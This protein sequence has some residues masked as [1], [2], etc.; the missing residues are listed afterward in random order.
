MVERPQFAIARVENGCELACSEDRV[1]TQFR[2]AGMRRLAF[3]ADERTQ[4]P[5]VSREDGVV[6][7]LADHDQV[8]PRFLLRERPRAAAVSLLVSDEH[9]YQRATP[10]LPPRR[11]ET[12]RLGHGRNR[13]LGVTSAP[14]EKLAL[15]L[16]QTKRVAR[17]AAARGNR[18]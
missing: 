14:T 7:R 16:R 11:E 18:S 10:Q 17:P 2:P 15:P 1:H 6:G 8:R 9:D 4:T 5:F 3:G 13:A 12:S